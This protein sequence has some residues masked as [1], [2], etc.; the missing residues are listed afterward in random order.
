M[1]I[2]INNSVMKK[3]I[4]FGLLLFSIFI[5][6]QSMIQSVNSGSI[7]ALNASVSV[8]EIVIVPVN[9]A[10][11]SS[12][13]I[14]ILVQVNAQTLEVSQFELAENIS[15]YPNPTV[16]KLFFESKKNLSNEKII[17]SNELGKFIKENKID[18]SNSI[19][20]DE[21]SSGIYLIQFSNKELK[22]FKIIK[23]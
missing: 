4:T 11:P 12:G 3:N 2:E 15:V 8:G 7:I 18:V 17:I 19:D 21:L 22:P 1:F 9:T 23:K 20:L 5:N 13:I 6:A 10:Q 14:G 16:A